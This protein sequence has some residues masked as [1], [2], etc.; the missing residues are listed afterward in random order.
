[1]DRNRQ[2]GYLPI[3]RRLFDVAREALQRALLGLQ[4]AGGRAENP[5]PRKS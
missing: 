5:P 2:T 1:M 3:G 4:F